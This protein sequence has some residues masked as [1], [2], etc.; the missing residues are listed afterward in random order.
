MG[1]RRMF[2]PAFKARVVLEELTAVKSAAEI[3]REHQ[4]KPQLLSH[5]KAPLVERTPELF[6]STSNGS[7]TPERIAELERMVGR[8]P[9][10]L[11]VAKKASQLLHS[12]LRRN[13]R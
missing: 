3:C 10:E 9:L 2:T 8:L 7:E 4:V 6:G 1:A 5:W 13:G 12:G 11:E